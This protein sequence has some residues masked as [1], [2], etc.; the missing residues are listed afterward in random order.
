MTNADV[1]EINLG[2]SLRKS[3]IW[4]E[5]LHSTFNSESAG[6]QI[7]FMWSRSDIKIL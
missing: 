3:W 6:A 2:V 7:V 5:M 4:V 1:L